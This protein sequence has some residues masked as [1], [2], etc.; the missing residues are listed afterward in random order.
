MND[1][2]RILAQASR[3]LWITDSLRT[4]TYV[5]AAA[6]VVV[7]TAR[8]V[9]RVFGYAF[10]WRTIFYGTAA[11]IALV[12]LVWSILAR[13][14]A[15]SVAKVLDERAGLR[16]TLSTALY[17]QRSEDPWAKAVIETAGE[18]ARGVKVGDALPIESP[19]FWPVPVALAIAFG[20]VWQFLPEFDI[21]K[22]QADKVAK[23]E[24]QRAIV[25]VKTDLDSKKEEL[26]KA[27]EKAK[28]EFL[29]QS[30]EDPEGKDKKPDELD[31]DAMRR[32]AVK[33]LTD[34]TEK[35]E[36][37]KEGEKADQLDAMKEAMRQLKQPGDG[38]L[39]ELS[40]ALSRGD[41]NKAQDQLRQLAEKMADSKTSPEAKAQAKEQME[42]LAK[43]LKQLAENQGNLAKQLQKAG[44]DKKTAEE[45]AK[46]AA[47][48]PEAIQKALEKN[49]NLSEEQKQQLLEMAKA[50]CKAGEKCGKMGESMS[51]MAK[52]MTQDGLQQEGMEGMDDLEKELSESEM[53]QE[54]MANLDAALD[55]AKQ[56]LAE[57]GKC[58]GG[59]SDGT[60]QCEG[61]GK[62]GGWKP[63]ESTGKSGRGSGGPGQSAGGQAPPPEAADFQ[64]EKVKAN[65]QT[66]GGPI[67]GTRLVYG[68]QIKGE[69]IAEFS[70]VV[71]AGSQEAAEAM[72]SNTI[73][74]EYHDAVK[75]Y[76]GTLQAKVN[77]ENATSKPAAKPEPKK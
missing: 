47:T 35:L 69:S 24:K 39:N 44:L 34:L 57:L 68:E 64:L 7:L 12:T 73:P 22:Y 53:L 15:L 65:T 23:E 25:E 18:K 49:Q 14:R 61:S 48:N 36:A 52:G 50:A 21:F 60:G 33:R 70:D 62:T 67:I 40:R 71:A 9:E 29:D 11:G 17:M 63:G 2:R 59:D 77:K 55:A 16:E 38:P 6:F 8:V 5:L 46:A 74:R 19:R 54:D 43:Q 28:V 37:Q 31:P 66:Q 45:L 20:L 72:E 41:F 13:R 32:E 4:L 75:R 56:Q 58:L 42:N 51:K 76:F 27:L 30:P 10:P 26:R 3:R 1:I